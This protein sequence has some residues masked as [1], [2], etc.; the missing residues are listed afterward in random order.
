MKSLTR[1]ELVRAVQAP[2]PREGTLLRTQDGA[3]KH[4]I[5]AR[6][7]WVWE[8]LIDCYGA[9]KM[10]DFGDWP[11]PELCKIIDD[12]RTRDDL[13]DLLANI[14]SAYP[15]WPPTL[16]QIEQLAKALA[17]PPV[18]WSRINEALTDYAMRTKY[19]QMGPGQRIGIP[20]WNYSRKG[21]HI[22]TD[23]SGAP[24]IFISIHEVPHGE[25]V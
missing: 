23:G 17:T 12:V 8:R 1:G 6:A 10:Q 22:P 14:R 18:N 21:L 25:N 13:R 5:S 7:Q 2:P 11:G 3:P 4:R 15:N 24:A 9:T 16:A 20:R 19:A